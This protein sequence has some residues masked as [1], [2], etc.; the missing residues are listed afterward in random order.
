MCCELSGYIGQHNLRSWRQ[1][2]QNLERA[3]HCGHTIGSE[4]IQEGL[5]KTVSHNRHIPTVSVADIHWPANI[6]WENHT[7]GFL[8]PGSERTQQREAKR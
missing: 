5:V 6:A 3:F 7:I 2:I 8:H 4:I 1:I